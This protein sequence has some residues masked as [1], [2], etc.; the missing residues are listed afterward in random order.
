MPAAFKGQLDVLLQQ[1][2]YSNLTSNT[3]WFAVTFSNTPQLQVSYLTTYQDIGS[4]EVSLF[5]L[6]SAAADRGS[7]GGADNGTATVAASAA[8]PADSGAATGSNIGSASVKGQSLTRL[9]SYTLNPLVTQKHSVP[10][11]TFWVHSSV[12][13]H[14]KG[15]AQVHQLPGSVQ[16][17]E[18]LVS[19]QPVMQAGLSTKFKLLAVMSC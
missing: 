7:G 17:G 5:L 2:G 16:G 13:D 19:V 11:T 15:Q 6:S 4:A 10:R 3:I 1:H 18:Y 14:W 8:T 9:A 12:A